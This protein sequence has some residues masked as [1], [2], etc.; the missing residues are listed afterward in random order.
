MSHDEAEDALLRALRKKNTCV[1]CSWQV[2][3]FTE[4]VEHLSKEHPE[5]G[6]PKTNG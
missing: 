1:H 3:N 5:H 6:D 2:T 4:Y